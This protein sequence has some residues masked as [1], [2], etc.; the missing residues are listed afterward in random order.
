VH[1]VYQ[2]FLAFEKAVELTVEGG[3]E[4]LYGLKFFNQIVEHDHVFAMRL[5]AEIVLVNCLNLFHLI[6][7]FIV[8]N[9]NNVFALIRDDRLP[10]V[11][12]VAG[13][14]PLTGGKRADSGGKVSP[15]RGKSADNGGKV[16]PHGGKRADS[17]GKVSPHGGKRADNGGKVSP[18][19]GKRADSGGN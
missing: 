16:S 14:F 6:L 12:A 4:R 2:R 19:G 18:H 15:H 8:G 9:N 5:I 11:E 17:G 7:I 10:G 3:K 13:R 1:F